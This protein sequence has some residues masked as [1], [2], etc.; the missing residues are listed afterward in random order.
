MAQGV[1]SICSLSLY[2]I[3]TYRGVKWNGRRTGAWHE[4]GVGSRVKSLG[5]C[6]G[7]SS[8]LGRRSG[9]SR[10]RKSANTT[11]CF[12][13]HWFILIANRVLPASL[14][15][16]NR[17]RAPHARDSY[18]LL[19]RAKRIPVC[20]A[21]DFASY[22]S[23]DEIAPGWLA[24]LLAGRARR[25]PTIENAQYRGFSSSRERLTRFHNFLQTRHKC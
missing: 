15:L 8:S 14:M 5:L 17:A 11:W 19:L 1:C 20:I 25:L 2:S 22:A 10:P 6:A 9:C 12:C 21:A 3:N 13:V 23:S 18:Y 16:R 7:R 4:C 24:A